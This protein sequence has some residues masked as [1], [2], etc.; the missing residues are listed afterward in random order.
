MVLIA[1][2]VAA[3]SNMVLC[4]RLGPDTLIGV[5]RRDI[6]PG[7]QNDALVRWDPPVCLDGPFEISIVSLMKRL[8]PNAL[9][10]G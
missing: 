5:G 7:I 8:D 1:P 3:G 6:R 4:S 9:R 2:Y 10:Q